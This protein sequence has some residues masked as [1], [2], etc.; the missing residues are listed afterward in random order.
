M[1]YPTHGILHSF[2]KSEENRRV[3]QEY[4]LLVIAKRNSEMVYK[5][6]LKEIVGEFPLWRSG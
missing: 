5:R 2:E 3:E 6:P 4:I 1:V